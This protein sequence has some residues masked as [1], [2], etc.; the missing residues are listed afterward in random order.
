M[1]NDKDDDK[2][3]DKDNPKQQSTIFAWRRNRVPVCWLGLTDKGQQR[4]RQ[5]L[6]TRTRTTTQLQYMDKTD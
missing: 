4:G 1:N 5:E 3:D 6:T 2:D